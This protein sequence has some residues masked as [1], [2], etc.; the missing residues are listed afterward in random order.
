MGSGLIRDCSG[1][2]WTASR[3]VDVTR[4]GWDVTVVTIIKNYLAVLDF[5][6]NGLSFHHQFPDALL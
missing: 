3:Q 6:M 1:G 5:L 2:V 4:L